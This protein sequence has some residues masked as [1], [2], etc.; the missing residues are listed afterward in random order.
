MWSSNV[1]GIDFL[2]KKTTSMCCEAQ[3][4]LLTKT[5]LRLVMEKTSTQYGAEKDY[6][7]N[8]YEPANLPFIT[9]DGK[10]IIT[11]TEALSL[12]AIPKSMAIIGGGIIGVEMGSVYSRLGTESRYMNMH[13]L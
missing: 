3:D 7:R 10:Q 8:R 13:L 11:S 9:L 1:D 5:P 4:R 12:P 2:M 6:H